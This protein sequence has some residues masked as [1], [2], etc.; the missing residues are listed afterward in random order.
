MG[1]MQPAVRVLVVPLFLRDDVAAFA[2]FRDYQKE[3][4]AITGQTVIV[5]LPNAVA[6]GNAKGVTK[7][8]GG[9][10]YPGLK[11]SDFPCLWVEGGP[12][13]FILKLP[14]DHDGIRDLIR[15]L[16]AAVNDSTSF[17]DVQER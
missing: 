10:G 1:D 14:V 7:A 3:I 5:G 8:L 6:R 11:A 2:Y 15:K 17:K 4:S 16:V 13:H 12:D 9:T